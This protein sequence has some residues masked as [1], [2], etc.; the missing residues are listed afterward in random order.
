MFIAHHHLFS[1]GLLRLLPSRL[2]RITRRLAHLVDIRRL[3]LSLSHNSLN[4]PSSLLHHT[5]PA[6]LQRWV[7]PTRE[8]RP[9]LL[10]G[11]EGVPFRGQRQIKPRLAMPPRL[12]FSLL[13][14][15]A[16]S[17]NASLPSTDS[18]QTLQMLVH[19]VL[20][21]VWPAA[22]PES[23]GPAPLS[24]PR[25]PTFSTA[26]T[27]AGLETNQVM[28]PSLLLLPRPCHAQSP[29]TLSVMDAAFTYQEFRCLS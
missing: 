26:V 24:P 25:S 8:V 7:K 14:T 4:Q 15:L 13:S 23:P 21:L 17:H 10:A 11:R 1:P 6:S 28:S 20:R 19:L 5:R 29:G 16:L 22:V 9:S 2:C 12:I 27:S 3:S 18:L